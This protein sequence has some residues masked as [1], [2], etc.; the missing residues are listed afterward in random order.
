MSGEAVAIPQRQQLVPNAV[1]GMA[2]FLFTEVMIF[3]AL[4]A[5][6]LVVRSGAINWPPV[7][8]PQ[9]PIA[10]TAV[11]TAVLLFS[12]VTMILAVRKQ[13]AGGS[14][15]A[16]LWFTLLAG[17]TFLAIQGYEWVRIVGFGLTLDSSLYAS[18][19][20][21]LIGMHALHVLAAVL[22]L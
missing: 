17:S 6:Y 10:V 9:L 4:I 22:G 15:S 2:L 20:Y 16:L 1:L 8:Q 19:F 11:N 21:V 3:V 18:S 12:A 5:S 7:D 14:A 13:R